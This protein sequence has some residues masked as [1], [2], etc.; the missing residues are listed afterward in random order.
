MI[1]VAR[2]VLVDPHDRI[3]WT[4]VFRESS[5]G[6]AGWVLAGNAMD[7]RRRPSGAT[8]EALPTSL[9]SAG[10]GDD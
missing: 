10:R 2:G 9:A 3:L 8:R 6:G 5:F 1:H 4:I 7:G